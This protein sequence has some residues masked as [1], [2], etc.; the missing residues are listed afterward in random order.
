MTNPLLSDWTTE[1]QIAPFADISDDDFAPAVDAAMDEARANIKAITNNSDAPTFAN[2]IETLEQAEDTLGR[3]LGVFFNIAGAD[4]NSK[5][6]E[7]QRDFSPKLAAYSSE[8]TMNEALFQRIETLWE[9][10]DTLKLTE[11]QQR[12]L[13]LTR[14]GYVRSGAKLTGPPPATA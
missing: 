7:L 4:S 2:T 3:V 13:M 11:E 14:R 9:T 8:I 12:V 5:R 10:R 1:F 6:Q